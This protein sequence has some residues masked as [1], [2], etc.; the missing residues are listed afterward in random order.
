MRDG[1]KGYYT[2]SGV[3][4]FCRYLKEFL[5][6]YQIEEIQGRKPRIVHCTQE[7]SRALLKAV[8]LMSMTLTE[9]VKAQLQDC[10]ALVISYGSAEQQSLYQSSLENRYLD[11]GEVFYGELLQQFV[12]EHARDVA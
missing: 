6:H 10:A 1:Q 8:Q 4:S 2:Y 11:S 9:S 7:A 5:A 3:E 12:A